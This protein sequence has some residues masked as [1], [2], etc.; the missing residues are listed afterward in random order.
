MGD[1]QQQTCLYEKWS[2]ESRGRGVCG[3]P[4]ARSH[5]IR[6]IKSYQIRGVPSMLMPP[7]FLALSLSGMH[8]WS[9]PLAQDREGEK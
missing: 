1:Q 2:G 6:S 7:F 9:L 4:V 5:V 8:V 3:A